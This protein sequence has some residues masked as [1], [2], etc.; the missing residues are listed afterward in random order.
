[1]NTKQPAGWSSSIV[2]AGTLSRVIDPS[3]PLPSSFALNSFTDRLRRTSIC[4]CMFTLSCNSLFPRSRSPRSTTVTL[5][6]NWVRNRP[7]SS[8]LLPPPST[9]S[10]LAPL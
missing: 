1:M 6:T 3:L 2:P 4:L 9:T 10:S 7:S 5:S 8:P